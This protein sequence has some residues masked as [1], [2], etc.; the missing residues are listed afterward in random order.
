M[1]VGTVLALLTGI[2][3][4]RRIGASQAAMIGLLE[5]VSAGIGAWLLLGEVPT[6]VQCVGGALLLAG[7]ALT[8]GLPRSAAGPPELPVAPTVA[9]KVEP[10]VGWRPSGRTRS[11]SRLTVI[12]RGAGNPLITPH[13]SR[14]LRG[15]RAWCAVRDNHG[16]CAT[17]SR[18][19]RGNPARCAATPQGARQPR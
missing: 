2:A 10:L 19:V 14:T 12:G 9:P 11:P 15:S 13:G 7:I 3:A 4:V 17:S 8:Q 5:L 18:K 6:G 16:R 1:V